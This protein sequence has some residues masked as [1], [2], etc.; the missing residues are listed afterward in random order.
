MKKK[1]RKNKGIDVYD[2]YDAS[3]MIDSSR[4]LKYEDLGLKLP[5]EPPTKVISIRIPSK[6]LNEIKA[7]GSQHDIP[8]QALIKLFLAEALDKK[9]KKVA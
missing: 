4:P 2:K 9:R 6:L 1:R 8:Y 7:Y 5:E 3:E